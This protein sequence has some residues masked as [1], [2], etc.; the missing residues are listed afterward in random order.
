MIYRLLVALALVIMAGCSGVVRNAMPDEAHKDATVLGRSDL[1]FWASEDFSPTWLKVMQVEPEEIRRTHPAITDTEHHYLAI[2]G[3][4]ANGAYGAGLLVGW[5]ALGTRP[6]F[7]MVTGISTGALTAPFAFLGEAYDEQLKEVY[8]TLDTA[9][10]LELGNVFNILR[11]DAITD[12]TPL[13]RTIERYVTE[14][15]IA[16]IAAEY[17]G[18]R[19]LLIG[20]TNLDA[21]EGMYWNIGRIANTGHADS[22][23]LIREIL[24]ASASIPGVFPPVYIKAQTPD[25]ETYDEMHVD[26]GTSTQMFLYPPRID[27]EQM[28]KI[29]NVQGT[30]RA[31][32]IRN[33]YLNTDY[34]PVKPRLGPILGR[35][36]DSL[37]R[38]Q[39]IGDAYRIHALAE[40]DGV[41]VRLTWIPDHAIN[42]AAEEAFDPNYMKALF[43]FGYE[44]AINGKPWLDVSDALESGSSQRTSYEG[45]KQ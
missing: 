30:P 33:S 27:W 7:T 3:G 44:R 20:T 28:I 11:A 12:V 24:R 16:D 1:R 35:T 9:S 38:T 25:G 21:S 39:G 34:K 31:Y 42:V 36:I 15:M 29:L 14:D 18:G 10:I 4:G 40:R 22:L 23:S 43:E 8:T 19:T 17:R 45:M 2:S 6:E 32:L 13:R 37:I 41:D 5:S 26:G